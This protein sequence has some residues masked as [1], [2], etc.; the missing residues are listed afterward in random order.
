MARKGRYGDSVAAGPSKCRG[1]GALPVPS[2]PV[3]I[4]IVDAWQE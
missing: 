3:G 4:I 2:I 1:N